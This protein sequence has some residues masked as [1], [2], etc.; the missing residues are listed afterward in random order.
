VDSLWQLFEYR[1]NGGE[2]VGRGKPEHTNFTDS[3]KVTTPDIFS[4]AMT[5]EQAQ[6]ALTNRPN[7]ITLKG[8]SNTDFHSK[9]AAM[10]VA[11]PSMVK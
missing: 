10:Q 11:W 9:I 2:T 4:P 5:T 7:N 6:W 3:P 8:L 1:L